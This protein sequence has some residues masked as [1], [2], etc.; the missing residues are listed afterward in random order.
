MLKKRVT[1]VHHIG[2]KFK[3]V[4]AR[5][6]KD[7]KKGFT[8]QDFID[9]EM[10]KEGAA[11]EATAAAGNDNN[12]PLNPQPETKVDESVPVAAKAMDVD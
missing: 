10:K 8:V 2:E 4:A 7:E 12:A 9:K 3:A 6:K 11:E 5:L 1:A